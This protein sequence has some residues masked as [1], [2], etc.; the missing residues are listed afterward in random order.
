MGLGYRVEHQYVKSMFAACSQVSDWDGY[1]ACIYSVLITLIVP[2]WHLLLT[3]SISKDNHN[4]D[5]T[6]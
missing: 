2:C 1:A 6:T 5:V 4:V 3:F